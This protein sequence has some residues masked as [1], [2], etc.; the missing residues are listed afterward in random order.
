MPHTLTN[1][2]ALHDPTGYG[3]SHL[4]ATTG[5]LVFVAGQYGS[6]ADGHVVSDDFA[7]QV[8]RA[9]ANLGTAL[10]AAGLDYR[11]VARLGT[12]VVGH[13]ADRLAVLLEHVRRVWGDR[14]PAQTLLGVATLALPG[15][16]FEVDAVA[17]R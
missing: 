5:D 15:M 16:L 9:F 13:D 4:A 8:G 6:D 3:Y 1:P 17:V 10:R 11:H 2:D 7:E 12:Y 14:P